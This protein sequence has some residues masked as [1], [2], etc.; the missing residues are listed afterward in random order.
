[1]CACAQGEIQMM[2]LRRWQRRWRKW[3]AKDVM[4][5]IT[6]ALRTDFRGINY[7]KC[8]IRTSKRSA[9]LVRRLS[10]TNGTKGKTTERMG[11]IKHWFFAV[12]LR[13][14][15]EMLENLT[16][17]LSLG[18]LFPTIVNFI[19]DIKWEVVHN[20]GTKSLLP[21]STFLF[22]FI[23]FYSAFLMHNINWSSFA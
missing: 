15:L 6:I 21:T 19:P 11:K 2:K 13:S 5:I 18:F 4:V 16:L 14:L 10:A 22:T 7:S 3:Q 1:M 23:L 8:E 9:T 12:W 17:L 20:Y